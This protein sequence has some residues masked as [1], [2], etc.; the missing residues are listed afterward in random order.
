MGECQVLRELFATVLRVFLQPTLRRAPR[1]AQLINK[2]RQ[3]IRFQLNLCKE[4]TPRLGVPLHI[5][6]AQRGDE[7]LD[8]AQRQSELMRGCRQDL[9]GGWWQRSQCGLKSYCHW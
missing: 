5:G 7:P 9:L 4:L 8:V 1:G 3:A 6:S 2:P